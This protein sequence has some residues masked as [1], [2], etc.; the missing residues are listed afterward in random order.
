MEL[1][2]TIDQGNTSV[3]VTAFDCCRLLWSRRFDRLTAEAAEE[4][5]AGGSIAKVIFS[6]VA[7]DGGAGLERLRERAGRVYVL[8]SGLPV[9]LEVEYATPS[10]LGHD[11]IA[12]AVGALAVKP[13]RNLLVVDAGTAVTYDFVTADG[14]FLGGNIAPGLALRLRALAQHCEQLPD[15]AVSG[16]VPLI[17]YDTVTAMRCGAVR[18]MVAEV[19][20]MAERLSRQYGSLAAVLTGGDGSLLVPLLE[21]PEVSFEKDL[22]AIGLN[23]ILE[24]NELL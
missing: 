13:G 7:G 15:V 6:S 5:S 19:S 12:A 24:Y 3:K 18:G 2:L 1:S 22:V 14:R 9:P 4:I 16:D 10:T 17:G 23:R 20:Y 11:R 8:D 21:L